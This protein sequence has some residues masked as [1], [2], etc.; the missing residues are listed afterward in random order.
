[1]SMRPPREDTEPW[2]RQF[3]PWF[4]ITIPS[5]AVIG[6]ISTIWLATMDPDGLVKDDYYKEGLAINR[7]LAR[8]ELAQTLGV[9]ADVYYDQDTGQLRVEIND[10]EVGALTYLTLNISHPTRPRHDQ[11]LR[12][13]PGESKRIYYGRSDEVAL[14]NWRLTLTPPDESWRLHGRMRLPEQVRVHME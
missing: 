11:T 6:G 7:D 14:A 4:L 3:W 8:D 9:R 5:L 2:Y 1:M 13:V 12:L 10:A